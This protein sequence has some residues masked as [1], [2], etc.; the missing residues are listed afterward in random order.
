MKSEHAKRMAPDFIPEATDGDLKTYF[1][2]L[3]EQRWLIAGIALVVTLAGALYAGSIDPVYE[4]NLIVRTEEPSPSAT[5][6]F[7]GDP[8]ATSD[9]RKAATAEIELLRSRVVIAPAVERLH[10]DIVATPERHAL[11]GHWLD[12]RALAR[13][14]LLGASNRGR[15]EVSVFDVPE[16]L[17]GKPFT[18]VTQGAG[19]YRLESAEGAVWNGSAGQTLLADTGRGDIRL[20]VDRIDA[21]PGA[22]FKLAHYE[23]QAVIAGIQRNLTVAELGK[24]SGVIEV[25]LRG[26]DPAKVRDLLNGIG[27]EYLRRNAERASGQAQQSLALLERQLPAVKSALER[28]EAGYHAF[29]LKNGTVNLD[30]EAKMALMQSAAARS[31]RFEIEQKRNEALTRLGENHPVIAGLNRQL[32]DIDAEVRSTRAPARSLPLLEQEELRLTRDIK[33][34]TEQY[35]LLAN[36]VQQLRILAMGKASNVEL[37]DAAVLPDRPVKPNRPLLV[38]GAAVA[39]L[40]LGM[41]TALLRRALRD[42]IHSVDKLESTLGARVVLA[43]IPHSEEQV[44]LSRGS[45]KGAIPLLA[46]AAPGDPAIEALRGLRAALQFA[47]P[48][49]QNNIVM[50][51]GPTAGLGKSFVSANVAAVI[52]ASGRK[53]LLID[54]DLRNGE[55]H[56]YFG[57]E[58]SNGLYEAVMRAPGAERSIRYDVLENLDFV[59]TGACAAG[60]GE[61]LIQRD[62]DAWLSATSAQYDMVVVDAPP[63]LAVADAA[64]VGARAGAV[65]LVARAGITTEPQVAEAVRRLNQAGISPEGILFNGARLP[66]LAPEYQYKT[67]RAGRLGWHG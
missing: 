15:V 13:L 23:K 59:P 51:T 66:R 14:P 10:L 11:L 65:L 43:A 53:T 42:G 5:R 27:Q 18:L 2:A 35:A 9:T 34:N 4:A 47:L 29:R 57:V 36:A 8:A 30:E 55:L 19:G 37:V 28:A 50:I 22:R 52:A 17:N 58:Q 54:M 33:V 63:V 7:L 24:Q 48:R 41:V 67:L 40:M 44:R 62:F 39:G 31:K 21:A 61:L 26:D 60:T 38:F 1:R 20:L 56:R 32:A 45:R 6:N 25:R 3:L 16:A 49:F 64:I 46:T 12:S